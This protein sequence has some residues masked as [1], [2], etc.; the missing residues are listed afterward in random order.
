MLNA[1]D[2]HRDRP[3]KYDTA[4]NRH[5]DFKVQPHKPHKIEFESLRL[6]NVDRKFKSLDERLQKYNLQQDLRLNIENGMQTEHAKTTTTTYENIISTKRNILKIKNDSRTMNIKEAQRLADERNRRS[7]HYLRQIMGRDRSNNVNINNLNYIRNEDVRSKYVVVS[8]SVNR[9][10]IWLHRVKKTTNSTTFYEYHDAILDQI[11]YIPESYKR[12]LKKLNLVDRYS[13]HFNENRY[14]ILNDYLKK[15]FASVYDVSVQNEWKHIPLKNNI[16]KKEQIMF[17]K[18][19]LKTNKQVNTFKSLSSPDWSTLLKVIYLPDGLSEDLS[20]GRNTFISEEC[21]VSS[22]YL[23]SNPAF[24][25]TA[26]LRVERMYAMK[27]TKPTGQIWMSWFLESPVNSVYIPQNTYK[28]RINWT[29][30]FR[31]DSII[32]TPYAK[33]VQHSEPQS[34][35][36]AVMFLIL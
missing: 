28:D 30:S 19:F 18:S 8:D 10:D 27:T 2:S 6:V 4:S 14:V 15:E 25:L 32:V 35:L 21:L 31:T 11:N 26:H 36:W 24:E 23:T 12:K 22:C 13:K 9:P 20:Y 3:Q 34:S 33:Y 17:N 1:S 7:E 29:A 5:I 16:I